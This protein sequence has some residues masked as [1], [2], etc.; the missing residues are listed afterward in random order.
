MMRR[1]VEARIKLKNRVSGT[2]RDS[3]R[4]SL[5]TLE[6]QEVMDYLTTHGLLDDDTFAKNF[7]DTMRQRQ[8]SDQWISQK[9]M[10]KGLT[11]EIVSTLLT[12]TDALPL[13][14]HHIQHK[15]S[16]H[17]DIL[18]DKKSKD[19]LIRWLLGKGFSYGDVVK[20]IGQL[21]SV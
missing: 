17:P 16:F 12:P 2:Q 3:D 10:Q 9:L 8:K 4:D 11:R 7:I 5:Q 21:Q 1:K 13:I 18:N 15:L 14:A 19:K 6:T 20:A